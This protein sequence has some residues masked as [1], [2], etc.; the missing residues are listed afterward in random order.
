MADRKYFL[1]G[2]LLKEPVHTFHGAKYVRFASELP[3]GMDAGNKIESEE[4]WIPDY[5]IEKVKPDDSD[6]DGQRQKV[7]L[8]PGTFIVRMVPFTIIVGDPTKV[9]RTDRLTFEDIQVERDSFKTLAIP[10][11]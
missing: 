5:Y 10:A 8:E 3:V 7:E 1:I 2:T 9:H 4:L 6:P 11:S